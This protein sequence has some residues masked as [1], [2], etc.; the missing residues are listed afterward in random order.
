MRLR[1]GR[2]LTPDGVLA[3]EV[4]IDAGRIVAVNAAEGSGGTGRVTGPGPAGEAGDA[5]DL[6]RDWI[7]PGLIDLHVHGGG[8]AQF[9]TTDPDEI[10]AAARFHARHG[11]TG[12]LATTVSAP[13]ADLAGALGAFA[14]A[15]AGPAGRLLLGVHLEGPFVSVSRPGAMDPATFLDPGDASV[16]SLLAAG[17]DNVTM[18]TVAPELPGGL[19]L[20]QRLTRAGIIASVGHSDASYEQTVAAVSA[21]VRAATH[22][23]NAMAP[24]H[25]RRP[26]L[27][28]AVLD[29]PEVSCELICDGVHADPAALR[30]AYRAKGPAA[31]RLVTDAISATGM[32][33]GDYRLGGVA[34]RA[35]AGRATVA[36][37]DSIAGSTLTIDAAVR[38]AVRFL[39]VELS[40]AVAMASA[41]PARLLGLEHRKGAIAPG[42]DADLTVLD[43]DLNARATL[44]GGMWSHPPHP[45]HPPDPV[46]G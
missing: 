6:G 44:V 43:D 7:V 21:G 12:L 13:L 33:D 26:G 28:G 45:P 36:S 11:A 40:E 46:R 16:E 41:N 8:G 35:H 15:R 10:T 38:N 5:L 4:L 3:G 29:L 32:A 37:G 34:V 31:I 22:T 27:L 25:H 9:N 17:G 18:M 2:I 14:R 20:I 30:L 39:G 23:F 24:F 1:S 42:M 19:A